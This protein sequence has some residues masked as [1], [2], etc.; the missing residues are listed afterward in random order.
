MGW[1]HREPALP[2]NHKLGTRGAKHSMQPPKSHP[3][4]GGQVGRHRG[5][6]SLSRAAHLPQKP[7]PEHQQ[8]Q[9][10]PRGPRRRPR[11]CLRRR[12]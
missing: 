6:P 7:P 3:L 8:P 12:P 9:R 11:H 2:R 5:L 4:A 1:V 10:H